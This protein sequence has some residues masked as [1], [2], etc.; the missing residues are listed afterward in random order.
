MAKP[1]AL[2]VTGYGINCEEETAYVFS[3]SGAESEI[4][5]IN[6]LISKEK[7][8]EDYQIMAF[9]G[10]FSYG[11]DTGSGNAMANKIKNNFADEMLSFAQQDKLIIGICNGFQIITNLG[12]V[13]ATNKD[14]AERQAVLMHN[15]SARYVCKW[16]KVKI[17]SDKC[18]WTKGIDELN[19]PIAH[20]EGNF[21]TTPEML[22]EL[23]NN[24][25]IALRYI[26]A[27]GNFANGNPEFNPNGAMYDIA[28]ICDPTGRI[29]GL[30]PHPERFNSFLNQ[31]DWPLQKELLIRSGKELPTTG[32]GLKIFQN[33]VNYFN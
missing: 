25:Q 18:I 30:M 6:D 8:L 22:E 19:L 10:G 12:L 20:G 27:N 23:K 21:Y 31:E 16:I 11:D 33:A 7:K 17:T 32:D 24:D 1:K 13:P 5:H 15:Q 9:P 14:Y 26:D 29:M 2:I 3:E 28:G 4:V